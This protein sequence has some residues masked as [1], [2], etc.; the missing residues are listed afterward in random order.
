MP[1]G[2]RASKNCVELLLV[3]QQVDAPSLLL[4][5]LGV[6]EQLEV[7]REERRARVVFHEH[8]RVAYEQLARG[9]RIDALVRHAAARWSA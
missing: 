5:V 1:A 2:T 4:Q 9:L 3:A 8:Q 7:V 6:L